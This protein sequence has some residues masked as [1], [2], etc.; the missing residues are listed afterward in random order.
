[1]TAIK[2]I[3]VAT[4]FNHCSEVALARALAFAERFEATVHLLHVYTLPGLPDGAALS[5]SSIDDAEQVARRKLDE[6]AR[7]SAG[8]RYL[9]Q[10]LVRMGDPASVIIL[11]AEELQAELIVLGTHGR[12]G[13]N[14]LLLGSVANAVVRTAPCSVLVARDHSAAAAA[15]PAA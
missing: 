5:S 12:R 10:L 14:R 7:T 8:T 6:V 13:L 9:G 4:D 15:S 3:L 1:M 2:N 11:V